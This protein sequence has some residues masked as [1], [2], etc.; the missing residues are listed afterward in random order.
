[1]QPFIV[2]VYSVLDIIDDK[3]KGVKRVLKL[4]IS[5]TL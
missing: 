3:L 4:T 1:M 5:K 2:T